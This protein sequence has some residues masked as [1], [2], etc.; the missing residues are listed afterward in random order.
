MIEKIKNYI[1]NYQDKKTFMLGSS[2]LLRM[3]GQYD[4]VRY[5]KDVDYKIFSQ[6]GEDGILDYILHN[7]KIEKPKFL[8]IGVGDYSES[9]TRFLYQRTSPKG[10]VIDCIEELEFKIKKISNLWKGDLTIINKKINTSN[11]NKILDDNKILDKLDLFSLDID[12][13]DYWILCELPNNFSK[14]VVVEYNPTF[15]NKLSI[16]VPKIENFNRGNYH[17]SNLCFGMSLQA[18]I[19]IMKKKNFYFLG[20]NLMRNNAFFV[21]NNYPKDEYFKNLIIDDVQ[22]IDDSNFRESRDKMG[23]L[24]YISGEYKIKEIQNCEVIDISKNKIEKITIKNLIS[25]ENFS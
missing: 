7:L 1:K 21:S 15:G 16:T 13:I 10:F 2:H 17:Y 14:V 18:A 19:E 25:K 6:N 20:V 23:N 22:A 5:I 11:I 8:E 24:N 4:K 12:G 3:R 9:N